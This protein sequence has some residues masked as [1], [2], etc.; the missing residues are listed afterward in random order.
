VARS[1]GG[2]GRATDDD[3]RRRA[4]QRRLFWS[5]MRDEQ[6]QVEEHA[7]AIMKSAARLSDTVLRADGALRAGRSVVDA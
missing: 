6:R 1:R 4:D 2:R 3:V 5:E 7:A